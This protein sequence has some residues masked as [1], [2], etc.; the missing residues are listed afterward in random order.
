MPKA[1][2]GHI[3][4]GKI[5]PFIVFSYITNRP[6]GPPE[7]RQLY[8]KPIPQKPKMIGDERHQQL[9]GALKNIAVTQNTTQIQDALPEPRDWR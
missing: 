7:K 8:S 9:M 4:P 1:I 3:V 2:E 6:Y 5:S